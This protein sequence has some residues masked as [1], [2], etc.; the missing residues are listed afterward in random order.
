MLHRHIHLSLALVHLCSLVSNYSDN[1]DPPVGFGVASLEGD[2][3]AVQL[4]WN[5]SAVASLNRETE[6]YVLEQSVDGGEFHQVCLSLYNIITLIS[7]S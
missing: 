3:R 1:P 7:E 6:E 2:S 5:G 4:M